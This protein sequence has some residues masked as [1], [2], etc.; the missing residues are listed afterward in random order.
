MKRNVEKILEVNTRRDTTP[1]AIRIRKDKRLLSNISC[2][3]CYD[4]CGNKRNN[5][6]SDVKSQGFHHLHRLR[7]YC[8]V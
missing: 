3:L 1:Q 4:Q 8:S 5:E 7:C 6:F 2:K